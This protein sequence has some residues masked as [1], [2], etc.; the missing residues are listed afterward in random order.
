MNEF[1]ASR[2]VCVGVCERERERKRERERE[3]ER[4]PISI[5]SAVHAV[6][7]TENESRTI[8]TPSSFFLSRR[9]QKQ[10][11]HK[12][13]MIRQHLNEHDNL[14]AVTSEYVREQED[15]VTERKAEIQLKWDAVDQ[16]WQDLEHGMKDVGLTMSSSINSGVVLLNVGGSDLYLPSRGFE[17]KNGSSPGWTLRDLFGAGD[18]DDRLPRSKNGR[19]FVDQSP[20]CVGYLI[21]T[22]ANMSGRATASP[23]RGVEEL[24][25]DELTYLAHV[26]G[27][28]GFSTLPTGMAVSGGS[29][30]LKADEIGPTTAAISDWCPGEPESLQLLYRASRDG[31]TAASFH[32]KCDGVCSTIT[33]ARVQARSPETTDSIVGGFSSVSWDCVENWTASPGAFVFM[34]SDGTVNP[35]QHSQP[36]RWGLKNDQDENAVYRHSGHGPAFGAGLDFHV[37]LN[38]TP[39]TLQTSHYTYDIPRGSSYLCLSHRAVV[40]VEVFR[41][42]PKG[43]TPPTTVGSASHSTRKGR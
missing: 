3:R 19:V 14:S 32:S 7:S 10:C 39:G 28:L 29:T 4:D 41:V 18:W 35:Q 38:E 24:P 23:M 16:G 36:T 43:K 37:A 2:G 33:L 21:Q 22:A 30:V 20:S 40:E 17:A 31:W 5:R 11:S 6:V 34:L 1:Q 42:W 26:A 25:A 12:I 8:L 15:I 13:V 9:Q 27:T